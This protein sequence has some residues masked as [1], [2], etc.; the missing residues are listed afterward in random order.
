MFAEVSCVLNICDRNRSFA[1]QPSTNVIRIVRTSIIYKNYFQTIMWL[2]NAQRANELANCCCPAIDGNYY[3]EPR[4]AFWRA[5]K[6]GVH[7]K[8]R[9]T[10]S[11]TKTHH[12][13]SQ[14]KEFLHQMQ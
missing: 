12:E 4:C 7:L 13:C 3:G 14:R 5:A 2:K 8:S 11:L 6:A 10:P 9:R 1:H